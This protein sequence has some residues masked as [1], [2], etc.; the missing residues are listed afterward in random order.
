MA[1]DK[2]LSMLGLARRAGVLRAGHDAT[3]KSIV[4][5]RAKCVLYCADAS[6]RLVREI[7]HLSAKHHLA[8]PFYPLGCTM[9]ALY[10]KTGLRCGILSIEDRHFADGIQKLADKQ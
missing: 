5:R 6:E 1:S 8:A 10:A 2:L 9:Q 3:V 4:A 7:Q